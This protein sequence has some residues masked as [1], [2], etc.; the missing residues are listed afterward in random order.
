MPI[1]LYQ[2]NIPPTAS[3]SSIPK[4]KLNTATSV[5]DLLKSQGKASDFN[6]RNNIYKTSGLADRLGGYVSSANQNI[7][8]H[9]Y[10]N[11]PPPVQK[12][13]PIITQEPE[14]STGNVTTPSGAIVN[15]MTGELVQGPPAGYG[16]EAKVI[17]NPTDTT[18]TTDTTPAYRTTDTTPAY[19]ALK[20]LGLEQTPIN[21]QD[22]LNQV[23]DSTGQQI[24]QQ[25]TDL[26]RTT[27]IREAE[28]QKA[29]LETQAAQKKQEIIDSLSRR[30]ITAF[31]KTPDAI[32]AL[33]NELAASKLG[34]AN[35]LA[36][37]LLS[38]NIN[39]RESIANDVEKLVNAAQSSNDKKRTAALGILENQGL[40]IDLQTGNLVPTLAAKKQEESTA[41]AQEK[42]TYQQEEA[43]RKL[44]YQ[45]L[46]ND[47]KNEL[48][49]AKF[50]MQSAQNAAQME[51]AAL[52]L[53]MATQKYNNSIDAILPSPGF[54]NSKI[55]SD[56]RFN[57]DK[58]KLE[59]G[60]AVDPI[61]IYKRLRGLHSPQEVTDEA[62]KQVSGVEEN[63]EIPPTVEQAA[64]SW[65]Q[66]GTIFNVFKKTFGK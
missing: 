55:E 56:I 16:S 63:L 7:A 58:I 6:S 61:A 3:V 25:R 35:D 59:S 21:S 54:Y 30:G 24:Q 11:N 39:L 4:I 15:P 41:L 37:K 47:F 23:M 65:L 50:E 1:S 19:N 12:S 38:Q 5:V 57:A 13:Q 46:Q 49:M 31:G 8:L 64:N 28:T 18:R 27:A 14:Q 52:R 2:Q 33:V 9:K 66:G 29:Q 26:A 40:T 43:Q 20:A 10:I 45:Q 51:N 44:E 22:I 53:D 42:F 32:V 17:P 60:D 48:A 36:D 34:V 62:L